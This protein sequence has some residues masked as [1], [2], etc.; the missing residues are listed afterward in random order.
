MSIRE[1]VNKLFFTTTTALQP[2][3]MAQIPSIMDMDVDNDIIR[4]RF[5][6]S[7]RN[8]SRESSILLNTSSMAYYE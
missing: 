4:G 6:S 5:T 8:E 3:Q 2:L 1:L 7:S